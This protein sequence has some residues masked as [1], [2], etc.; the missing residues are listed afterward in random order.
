MQTNVRKCKRKHKWLIWGCI[1][2]LFQ[3]IKI[4]LLG[5]NPKADYCSNPKQ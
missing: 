5:T 1:C 4:N 3:A 2:E